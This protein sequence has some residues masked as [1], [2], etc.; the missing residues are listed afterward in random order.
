MRDRTLGFQPDLGG[1]LPARRKSVVDLRHAGS[2]S[3]ETGKMPV[4]QEIQ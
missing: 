3:A 4:L 1:E 2:M